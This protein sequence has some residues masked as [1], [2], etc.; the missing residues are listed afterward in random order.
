[1]K[2]SISEFKSAVASFEADIITQ[3]KKNANK[4]AM[5]VAF[6]AAERR[7]DDMVKPFLDED[8]NVDVDMM[9]ERINTGLAASGGKLVI[10]PQIDTALRFLGIGIE[11]I[12]ITQA[13]FDDFFERKIPA[14]AE[15]G[16]ELGR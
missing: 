4:F 11:N 3:F 14:A 1:M 10:E 12:T 8:G 9:R 16:K 15:S 2:I 6:G 7:I 13:E 5:G